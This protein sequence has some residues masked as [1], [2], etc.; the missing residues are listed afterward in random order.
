M[1]FKSLPCFANAIFSCVAKTFLQEY[2][3]F[4]VFACIG[5]LWLWASWIRPKV[6][7]VQQQMEEATAKKTDMNEFVSQEEAMLAARMRLQEKYATDAQKRAE[8]AAK[9][10]FEKFQ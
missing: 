6:R 8:E 7:R 9:V 4:A 2:G 1:N 3:W 10:R 5:A